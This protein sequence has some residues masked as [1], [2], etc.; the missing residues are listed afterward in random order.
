MKK[1]ATK[2]AADNENDEF[3]VTRLDNVKPAVNIVHI[4]GRIES[5]EAGKP[6]NVLKSWT[7]VLSELRAIEARQECVLL[8][9]DWNRAIGSGQNVVIGNKCEVSY[10][11]KLVRDLIASG[12]YHM[13]LN[14]SQAEGGVMTRVCPAT[15]RESCLDFPIGSTNLLPYIKRVLVDSAREYAPRRAATKNGKLTLTFTDHYPV[16]VDLEMPKSSQ[17]MEPQSKLEWNTN[18]P[19]GWEVYQK[20]G[21]NN[22]RDL[23]DLAEDKGYSSEEVSGKVE[24]IHE[25]MKWIAFGKTKPRTKKAQAKETYEPNNNEEKAI[26]LRTKETERMEAEILKVKAM[27]QGRATKV[28]KMREIISGSKNTGKE[29]HAIKDPKTDELVVSN[30]AIKEVTLNYCLE[31]LKNNEPAAEVKQLVEL[32]EAV[33]EMRMKDKSNDEEYEITDADFLETVKKFEAKKS[34]SYEF[35]VNTGLE[36]KLAIMKLCKR[37]IKTEDFPESFNVTTLVQLPK[38][39]SQLL[40]ENSRFIH[41]K[42]WLPRIC[43]ALAV[44]EMKGAI[45]SAGT[46]YQIGGCPGQRT[47]FHLFVTKSMIA[48]RLHRG[49]RNAGTILTVADIMKFFDKQSLVDAMD[50]LYQAKINPKF[51]RVWYKMNENTVIQVKTGGGMSAR[52]MAGPVTGQGGG[53]AALASAL[54]LD[55]GLDSYFKGSKDEECY[56]TVRLQPLIYM[57]DTARAS[58]SINAMRAGNIKLASLALEKQLEYHPRKSGYLIFGSEGFK[59]ACRLDA[60]ESPVMLGSIVMKEKFTEKYLGDLLDSMGLSASVES[61][62]KSREAKIKGSIYELRALTEDF[63]MQ[64]VGGAQSAIDLYKSCIISSLLTNAGTW[65]EMK[66]ESVSRLDDIQDTFSR[67][68]LSLPL[69]AP[70]ASLRAALGLQAMKWRVWEAKILL[71]Q[72]IRRQEEGNLAREVLEEQLQ[73]GWPGLPPPAS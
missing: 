70:R 15:G 65:V 30:T 22:A 59:A 69:S 10:G 71:M 18:K 7:K 35:L 43:E 16:V 12:D 32:K 34:R 13:L 24:K 27:K 36:Y 47:Q 11:G 9:G 58:H 20:A 29:A 57:D 25:K 46:K 49:G 41:L 61:T 62:I 8:C 68:L 6:E 54:N 37:F 40:L 26:L 66:E 52:G 21:E 67:A 53:G 51:Y 5:R 23:C 44:R 73:M 4:Y 31:V 28:F 50:S 64:G 33:H 56:G 3:I 60:Q 14:T 17:G 45:F 55:L 72:A 48:L 19:G 2:I 42:E 1:Y 38:S 63:R 39:G